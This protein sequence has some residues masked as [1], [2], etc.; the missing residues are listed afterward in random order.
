MSKYDIDRSHS[1]ISFSAKHLMVTTVRGRFDTF[2]GSVEGDVAD[3]GRASAEIEIDVASI[4]TGDENRDNHLRSGD[5]FD[6]AAHP[7]MTWKLTS[8]RPR[9]DGY[10]VT[11]DLTI[12]ETTRPVT[13]FT[14]VEGPIQDPFGNERISVTATGELSRKEWGLTWNVGLETGGVMVSDKIK[15][16][17]D[18]AVIR[19]V[20]SATDAA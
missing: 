16:F 7:K 4:N 18:A 3:P 2:T 8:V 9:G 1:S 20:E 5:F 11:G 19:K 13:L 14:E 17:V 10:D 15:L 12:R 6:A